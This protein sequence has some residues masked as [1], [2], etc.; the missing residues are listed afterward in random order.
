MKQDQQ[1][2]SIAR[3]AA[4]SALSLIALMVLA[5]M[6]SLLF[7]PGDGG[8]ALA[9]VMLLVLLAAIGLVACSLAYLWRELRRLDRW[10]FGQ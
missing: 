10:L 6:T 4:W 3:L 2:P 5:S 8:V 1:T 7:A 9:V